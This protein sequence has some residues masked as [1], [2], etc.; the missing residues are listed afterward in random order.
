[1]LKKLLVLLTAIMVVSL[2]SITASASPPEDAEGVWSYLPNLDEFIIYKVADGNQF[3]TFGE[4]GSWTG[5]ISGA[6]YDY[7]SGVI[8][9]NGS[10]AFKGMAIL[11]SAT[12]DGRTGSL[13]IKLNGSRPDAESNWVGQ[14]VLI[15]GSLHEAGLRGQGTFDGPGWQGIPGEWGLIPYEGRVHFES[16]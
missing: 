16:R 3:M 10:W 9:A 7:G 15:G 14:W 13:E 6:S 12:V 4:Q 5:T 1:M 8:H 11:D 2:L